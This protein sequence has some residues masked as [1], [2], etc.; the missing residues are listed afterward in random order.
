[1]RERIN[2][3]ADLR[4]CVLAAQVSADEDHAII[5]VMEL[6]DFALELALDGAFAG[7]E[8]ADRGRGAIMVGDFSVFSF[9]GAPAFQLQQHIG[10]TSSIS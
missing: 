6:S 5:H 10:V 4:F 9:T 8:A 2:R 1:L 7:N 3:R